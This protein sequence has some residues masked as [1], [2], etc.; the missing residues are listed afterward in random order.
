MLHV[1][2]LNRVAPLAFKLTEKKLALTAKTSS[3]LE[4]LFHCCCVYPA[5][6]NG[7]QLEDYSVE[8]LIE[9]IS[10]MSAIETGPDECKSHTHGLLISEVVNLA[11]PA[12]E[13][14]IRFAKNV[15]TP[16]IREIKKES[17]ILI[18]DTCRLLENLLN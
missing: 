14:T 15:V 10:S 8:E 13:G 11:K 2:M 12:V 7:K 5:F 18:K 17:M 1:N 6:V 16:L 4:E 3:P 9:M